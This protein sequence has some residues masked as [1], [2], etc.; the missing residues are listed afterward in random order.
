MGLYIFV[1]RLERG[2]AALAGGGDAGGWEGAGGWSATTP[3][4]L[5]RDSLGGW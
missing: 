1:G 2:W 3:D 4:P 5:T